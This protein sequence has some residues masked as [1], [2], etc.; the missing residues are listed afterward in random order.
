MT[1]QHL[2]AV[3]TGDVVDSTKLVKSEY[4]RLQEALKQSFAMVESY[5]SSRQRESPA[6]DKPDN[7]RSQFRIFRGDSF[8]GLLQQPHTALAA[9]LIIRATLRTNR[10]EKSGITPDARIAVGIGPVDYLPEEITEGD[11]EAFRL[12]GPRLDRMKSGEYLSIVTPWSDVNDE[13][14]VHTSLL[15][16]IIGRWTPEQAETVLMLLEGKDRKEIGHQLDISQAAVHYRVKGAGWTAVN[17]LLD[18]Y[19]ELLHNRN[20]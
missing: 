2:Y 19:I 16:T 11:G 18:R 12:S 10:L 14:R 8:Q 15:D 4:A 20:N 3:L 9:S 13:L 17:K 1:R 5:T 7:R 6:S